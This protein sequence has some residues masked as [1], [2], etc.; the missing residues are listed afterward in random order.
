MSPI[1]L[2]FNCMHSPEKPLADVVFHEI[3]IWN[4]SFNLW[5]HVMV[6]C[7]HQNPQDPTIYHSL[8]TNCS[9]C[10]FAGLFLW[11][12]RTRTCHRF[13]SYD[14]PPCICRVNDSM[15]DFVFSLCTASSVSRGSGS[16][17]SGVSL[18]SLFVAT[19][20][21]SLC[22]IVFWLNAL[23]GRNFLNS[24]LSTSNSTSTPTRSQTSKMRCW[25]RKKL[26]LNKK[27]NKNRSWHY[28]RIIFTLRLMVMFRI[29]FQFSAKEKSTSCSYYEEC[30]FIP[31]IIT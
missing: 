14:V 20:F 9:I 8:M 3:F 6:P 2:S 22:G 31:C 4:D 15:K 11:R 30:L 1:N 28:V 12:M 24:S 23:K 27:I 5:L 17:F 19:A 29:I 10:I 7:R 16:L 26:H 18:T 25:W 13:S 21:L